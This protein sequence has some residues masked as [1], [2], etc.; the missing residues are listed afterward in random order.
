[1]KKRLFTILISLFVFFIIFACTSTNYH[2]KEEINITKNKVKNEQTYYAQDSDSSKR[3]ILKLMNNEISTYHA[4]EIRTP[5]E[6]VYNEA[7]NEVLNSS[8][9]SG[10]S[11][12]EGTLYI[13]TVRDTWLT[14]FSVE[15]FKVRVKGDFTSNCYHEREDKSG[16]GF[17][18]NGFTTFY[19]LPHGKYIVTI[20]G[21]DK[22]EGFFSVEAT[23]DH[24][25]KDQL[26]CIT[27]ITNKHID[28]RYR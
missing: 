7:M 22:N 18:Q 28:C 25:G 10:D 27:D 14:K 19:N 2:Q 12:G 1:M 21:K 8:G 13:K 15:E 3:D 16:N 17:L 6:K 9:C 23:I 26:W 11:S 20:E 5:I 4:N 24:N